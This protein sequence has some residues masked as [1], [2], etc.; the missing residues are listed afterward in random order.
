MIQF[1]NKWTTEHLNAF[2][3]FTLIEYWWYKILRPLLFRFFSHCPCA[4]C[5]NIARVVNWFFF[6]RPWYWITRIKE[7]RSKIQWNVP[8]EMVWTMKDCVNHTQTQSSADTYIHIVGTAK[9]MC[10]FSCT[11]FTF[12]NFTAKSEMNHNWAIAIVLDIYSFVCNTRCTRER[13]MHMF[14]VH[15][16]SC[17]LECG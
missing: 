3:Y 5:I 12:H 10:S 15:S 11:K 17:S 13:T 7:N 8:L 1:N 9:R 14:F 16:R 6:V 2:H 4:I